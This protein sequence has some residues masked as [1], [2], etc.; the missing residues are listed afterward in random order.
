[1]LDHA[2]SEPPPPH[3]GHEGGHTKLMKLM[4]ET[5]DLYGIHLK[6]KLLRKFLT[7]KKTVLSLDPN[8]L[9]TKILWTQI[10][11]RYSKIIGG[12]TKI[13]QE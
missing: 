4:C 9:Y 11:F 10:I 2:Q 1:M 6:K 8:Y 3:S 7:I 5:F 13:L 12:F